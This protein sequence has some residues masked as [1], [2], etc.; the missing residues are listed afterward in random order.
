MNRASDLTTWIIAECNDNISTTVYSGI[1]P[2][3]TCFPFITFNIIT[4]TP[5]RS[6]CSDK[7]TFSIQFSIFD[8]IQKL[9]SVH[10]ILDELR[11]YFDDL[12]DEAEDIELMEY[13]NSFLINE[14]E[15]KGWQGV[16]T[17]TVY[18]V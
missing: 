12:Q 8:E 4:D 14:A 7:G 13:T 1:A 11:D 2:E 16:L 5:Y 3:G 9:S 10:S 18:M 6:T 15:S 17:Y